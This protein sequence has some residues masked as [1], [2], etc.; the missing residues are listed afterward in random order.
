MTQGPF[1][2]DAPFPIVLALWGSDGGGAAISNE[3]VIPHMTFLPFPLRYV[4][5][6]IFDVLIEGDGGS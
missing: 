3:G 1:F 4:V 2:A 6:S 5:A